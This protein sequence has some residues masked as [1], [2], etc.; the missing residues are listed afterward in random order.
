MYLMQAI[1]L[2]AGVIRLVFD[3]KDFLYLPGSYAFLMIPEISYTEWVLKLLI[4]T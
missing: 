4:F 1:K 2:P 3:K